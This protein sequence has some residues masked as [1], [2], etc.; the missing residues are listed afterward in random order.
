MVAHLRAV[1]DP[2]LAA[3]AAARLPST[4]RVRVTHLGGTLEAELERAARA[5]AARNPRY[6]W[7]G[8][9]PR[10]ETLRRIASSHL[11]ALTSRSEGGASVVA[12]ALMADTPIVATRMEGAL[13]QLGADYPGY[14]EV[15]DEAGLAALLERAEHDAHFYGQLQSACALRRAEFEPARER[16]R[17]RALLSEL[18]P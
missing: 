4:S 8:A 1:K 16:E 10:R 13:G 7:L 15:G 2:L 9:R 11:L 17:W 3:R 5:E 6:R 18:A 14:F 12:E